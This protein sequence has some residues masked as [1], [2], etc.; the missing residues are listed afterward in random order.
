MARVE[1][2]NQCAKHITNRGILNPSVDNDFIEQKGV[3]AYQS[4]LL[5]GRTGHFIR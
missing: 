5:K 4:F 1:V 2:G 3:A